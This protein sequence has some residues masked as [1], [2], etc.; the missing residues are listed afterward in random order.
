MKIRDDY[1]LLPSIAHMMQRNFDNRPETIIPT[2]GMPTLGSIIEAS[3][4]L[5]RNFQ[6]PAKAFWVGGML[7]NHFMADPKFPLVCDAYPTSRYRH[8]GIFARLFG[9][10]MYSDERWDPCNRFIEPYEMVMCGVGGS[11]FLSYK[12]SPKG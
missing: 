4:N 10:D 7:Y 12:Y 3:K 1:T 6:V 2:E 5:T 8:S 11:Y 9:L